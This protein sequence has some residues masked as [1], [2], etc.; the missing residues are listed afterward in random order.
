MIPPTS[1]T[2]AQSAPATPR[3]ADIELIEAEAWSEL[4]LHSPRD[5]QRQF[6]IT[7]ERIAGGVLLLANRSPTLAVNRVLGL[8]L[9]KPLTE[10]QLDAVIAAYSTAGVE[11]FVV[12][13]SPAAEPAA[14]PEWLTDRGFTLLSRI[15]KVYR[16]SD[17][18]SLERPP[19]P[20]LS[21]TEI[22]AE[23]AEV[24]EQIV[25]APLGVPEGLGPGIRSTVGR[26]GW[27][28]YMVHEGDRP[29]AGAAL[30]VRG[31]LGWFGLGATIE[32]DRRRGAQTAL[33]ARRFADA[34]RDGCQWVSA[35]TLAETPDRPNQSFRNMRRAGFATL[36]E[37]PNYL[38]DLRPSE[39]AP[40][41][42]A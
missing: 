31:R 36:Y 4:Q 11:R 2:G 19:D 25:A 39:S 3:A 41:P 21:V 35:D 34:A 10:R 15:A 32:S 33:F 13:W 37:R 6:G 18:V 22:G 26:P 24:Y 5:F 20:R 17:G 1:S 14:V 28:Y 12:Q 16:R 27:R 7:V 42:L 38:L 40:A 29:I 30:Y 8:G 9:T 23:D